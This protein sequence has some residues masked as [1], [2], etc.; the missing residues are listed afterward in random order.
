[1]PRKPIRTDHASD[2]PGIA[3]EKVVAALQ[4]QFDPAATVVHNDWLIDRLGHRRQFDVVVRGTFAGQQVL[5]VV[6]CKDE[7]RKVDN[8]TIDAFVT[9]SRDVNA[10]LKVIISRK[11]FTKPALEKCAD[12]G[13]QALSLM[14]DATSV[15]KIRV[16]ALW[17]ADVTRWGR[18]GVTL[19]FSDDPLERV[20]FEAKELTIGGKRVIDWFTNYLLDREAEI[21]DFGWVVAL[22]VAFETPQHV[23]VHPGREYLCKAIDFRAERLCD[24]LERVAGIT[25]SGFYDWNAKT[26]TFPPGQI[27]MEPVPVDWSQWQPRSESAKRPRSG[28]ME[29]RLQCHLVQFERVPDAIQLDTL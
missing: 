28:F 26:A 2:R 13:I 23:S 16:G 17:E 21:H 3:F 8:P 24:K 27:V 22:H 29:F 20:V 19:H 7:A 12:N 18:I 11:G 14:N 25:S 1:M 10:N 9:K 6:E 15:A 4:A 5:G